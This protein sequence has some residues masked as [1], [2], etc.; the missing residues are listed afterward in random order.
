ME[1]ITYDTKVFNNNP[2]YTVGTVQ[3]KVDEVNFDELLTDKYEIAQ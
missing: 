2:G 3:I 1:E